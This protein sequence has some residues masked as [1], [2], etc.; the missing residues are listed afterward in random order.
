[1]IVISDTTPINYLVL[2]GQIELL[3][4]L[5]GRVVIPPAVLAELRQPGSPKEVQTWISSIPAWLEVRAPV[6]ID[7]TIHLGR[8][9][10][11][12]ISLARELH[13]TEVLIDDMQARKAALARGLRVAGTLLVLDRA[14]RRGWVNLPEA[15]Q[16]L[17]Q[18]NFRAPAALVAYLIERDKERKQ[19]SE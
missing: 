16:R 6:S 15:I 5:F 13:A 10:T 1:M 12:A 17:M 2:I 19:R 3:P 18:T 4:K 7:P 9:E 11:E 14:G 8:G